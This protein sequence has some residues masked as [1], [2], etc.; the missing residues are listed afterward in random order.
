M[1]CARRGILSERYPGAKTGAFHLVKRLPV[2]AG[3]GGGSSDA[4]AALR[5]LARANGVAVDSAGILDAAKAAG[6][7]VPVCLAS[8]ARMMRGVGDELGPLLEPP[9]LIGLLVNPGVP[10][11]TKDG[12][13]PYEDRDG[14]CDGLWRASRNLSKNA[15]GHIAR[16]LAKGPQRHG[17]RGLPACPGHRRCIVRARRRA[18]LPPR[19]HV[20][21]GGDLFRAVQ[22]LPLRRPRQKSDIAHASVLVGEDLRFELRRTTPN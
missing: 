19:P 14:H 3:L 21:V 18:R 7:D 6:A 9:P 4:A 20:G 5:L 22:G 11:A 16:R 1:C 15:S 12:F 17:G 2:A 13:R 10:V 8:R